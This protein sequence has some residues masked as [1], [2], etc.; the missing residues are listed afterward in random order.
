MDFSFSDRAG[1]EFGRIAEDVEFAA[2]L[3]H[4]RVLRRRAGRFWAG[5][6][7]VCARVVDIQ[8]R[9]RT[10]ARLACDGVELPPHYRR[11]GPQNRP[12]G[13]PAS[14]AGR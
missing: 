12:L 14:K 13:R 2:E 3:R 4:R 9:P 7:S 8:G 5:G 10:G 6:P 11:P 1:G